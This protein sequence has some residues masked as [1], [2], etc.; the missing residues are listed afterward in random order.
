MLDWQTQAERWG[1]LPEGHYN[2]LALDI[3]T[4]KIGFASGHSLLGE[5]TPRGTMKSNDGVPAWQFF[6]QE[7]KSW[8]PDIIIIG[9]PMN[10]DGSDTFLSPVCQRVANK[11]HG[12]YSLPVRCVDERLSTREA[13]DLALNADHKNWKGKA[14]DALAACVILE[15]WFNLGLAA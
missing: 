2:A 4:H 15:S 8:K 13:Y 3:G 14:V 11:I 10:M 9:W 6:E 7:L 12:R 1:P 5:A